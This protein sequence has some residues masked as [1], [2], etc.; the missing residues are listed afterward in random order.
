M[1]E[2]SWREPRHPGD[3]I[4][5]QYLKRGEGITAEVGCVTI[6]DYCDTMVDGKNLRVGTFLPGVVECSPGDTPKVW[7][8]K[9]EY[10]ADKAAAV[11][12]FER[13]VRAAVQDG[14]V[15]TGDEA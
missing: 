12:I 6:Q 1:S 8:E 13:Y 15:M 2:Q 3:H 9:K 14:W 7:P 10:V 4:L 5:S 11:V